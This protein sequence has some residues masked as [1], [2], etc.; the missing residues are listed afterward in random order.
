[1]NVIFE[2][3]EGEITATELGDYW[4]AYLEDEEVMAIRRTLVDLRKST[5]RFTGQEMWNLVESV[6]I[7]K[8][9]GR[10]W[11]T[12]ILV[13]RADQFGVSRQYQ[14]F[15]EYYSQDSIFYDRQLALDWLIGS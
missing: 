7:P 13:E 5:L 4:K 8:L 14:V 6:V 3:W 11:K 15:A 1:M 10:T 2:V 9:A 12:A